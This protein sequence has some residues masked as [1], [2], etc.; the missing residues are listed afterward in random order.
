MGSCDL[1][2]LVRFQ[3]IK[4]SRSMCIWLSCLCIQLKQSPACRH[5][6]RADGQNSGTLR[7]FPALLRTY[8]G[9]SI[10]QHPKPAA[11]V[12]PAQSVEEGGVQ[13][14]KWSSQSST[15]LCVPAAVHAACTARSKGVAQR[16]S[17][18]KRREP[19]CRFEASCRHHSPM[20]GATP[21][22]SVSQPQG[23]S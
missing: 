18:V 20:C 23:F 12:R 5:Q 8:T 16:L 4:S 2:G 11:A 15:A 9:G 1:G 7:A 14:S 6:S 3:R 17:L 10:Q 13:R 22:C 21:C 19:A